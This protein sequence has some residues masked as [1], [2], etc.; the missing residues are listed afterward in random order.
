L[1]PRRRVACRQHHPVGVELE[2]GHLAGG[3]KSIV[4]IACLL[5]QSEGERRLAEANDVAGDEFG[6]LHWL[7]ILE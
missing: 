6:R 5:G 2:L 3:Q 4:E 7:E 1:S